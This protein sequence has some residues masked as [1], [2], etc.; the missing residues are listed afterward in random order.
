MEPEAFP[1]RKLP[2]TPHERVRLWLRS[3]D[4]DDVGVSQ[5]RDIA[6][7]HFPQ[8]ERTPE[9]QPAWVPWMTCWLGVAVALDV[10]FVLAMTKFGTPSAIAE[11]IYWVTFGTPALVAVLGHAVASLLA[12]YGL[13]RWSRRRHRLPVARIVLSI[14]GAAA[15]L[16]AI[17]LT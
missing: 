14:V 8:A 10:L 9:P 11:G 2:V 12:V 7:H 15:W 4:A 17:L 13:A 6:L 5:P 1:R 16:G 3:S